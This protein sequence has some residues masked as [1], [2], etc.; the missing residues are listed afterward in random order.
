MLEK[1]LLAITKTSK[2]FEVSVE[3]VKSPAANGGAV[4]QVEVAT[5][6]G[7]NTLASLLNNDQPQQSDSLPVVSSFEEQADA[8]M[9]T[10]YSDDPL[11]SATLPPAN[12]SAVKALLSVNFPATLMEVESP[13]VGGN[14]ADGEING[15][16]DGDGD[17]KE[18]TLNT[19]Y[20]VD[21]PSQGYMT[22]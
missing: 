21:E 1:V 11:L 18:N 16:V 15:R 19:T 22:R 8:D 10:D 12:E 4:A 20:D 13:G 17:E 5:A 3:R 9:S 6:A 7:S 14:K 2:N